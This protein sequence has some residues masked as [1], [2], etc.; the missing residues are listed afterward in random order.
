MNFGLMIG[1]AVIFFL[2][3]LVVGY[4]AFSDGRAK[5][6]EKE[7]PGDI[8]QDSKQAIAEDSSVQS[9]TESY[10]SEPSSQDNPNPGEPAAPAPGSPVKGIPAQPTANHPASESPTPLSFS[11]AIAN[12]LTPQPSQP[13][14]NQKQSIVLQID[15]ILQESRSDV[16]ARR[17]LHLVEMQDHSMGIVLDDHIYESI[18]SLPD[19]EARN[20]IREAAREWTRR[21][22]A[23]NT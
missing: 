17:G 19:E 11:G 16:Y 14:K 12:L 18:D 3:G 1:L 13:V 23:D 15:E 4:L 10:I 2:L 8:I 6:G 5:P 20:L 7:S 9:Q 21:Q 22:K